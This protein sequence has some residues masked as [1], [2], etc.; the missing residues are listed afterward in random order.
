MRN[1]IV[2]EPEGFTQDAAWGE[3]R[4][5]VDK[6]GGLTHEGGE[7]NWRAAAGA[8]PGICSC[9]A[10]GEMFWCWGSKQRCAVC[11][12]EYPTDWWPMYSWGV[13]AAKN[14][15]QKYKHEEYMQHPYYRYGFEHPVEDAWE[16]HDKIDWKSVFGKQG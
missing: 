6:C 7:I 2:I 8:D 3:C 4:E 13:Q 16:Q 9:P 11:G 10:C 14:P 5:Y 15:K 1:P 12:F